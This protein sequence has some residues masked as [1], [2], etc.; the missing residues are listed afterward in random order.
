LQLGTEHPLVAQSL[1]NLAVLFD[2]LQRYDEAEQLYLR[3]LSIRESV[4]GSNHSEV[5]NSLYNLAGFYAAQSRYQEAETFHLRSQEIL[6]TCLGSEH[7]ITVMVKN[8]FIDFLEKVLQEGQSGVLSNH[9]ITQ[10]LLR[11]ITST[12]K[13]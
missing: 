5:A 1:N 10:S 8:N 7:Q 3:S 4:Y 11:S 13:Y 9:L 2:D 12:E 6:A